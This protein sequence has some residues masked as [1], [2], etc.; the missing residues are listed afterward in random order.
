VAAGTHGS[1]AIREDGTLWVWGE[2]W[3][4]IW[5]ARE[6]TRLVPTQVATNDLWAVVAAGGYQIGGLQTVGINSSGALFVW[7]DPLRVEIINDRSAVWTTAAISGGHVLVV[8]ENGSLWAYGR[9][10]SGQLG[11]GTTSNHQ[12]PNPVGTDA[13]IA[14]AA[15]NDHSLGIKRDGTLWAWGANSYGQLGD[16][17]TEDKPQPAPL[18]A[19]DRWKTVAAG[20]DYS[21][22]LRDDGTLWEW[23]YNVSS[24]LDDGTRTDRSEPTRV[25]GNSKWKAVSAGGSHTI[26]ISEDGGLWAWGAD[27]IKLGLDPVRQV[28]GGNV[29]GPPQP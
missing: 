22:A 4:R 17:T 3:Y 29:W 10:S 2:D 1:I 6:I 23:G 16:G 13:W 14:V 11:D 15:G 8:Q 20:G 19:N 9:N 18:A 25:A 21:I 12:S 24:W 7:G 5:G 27:S 26:A 28:L